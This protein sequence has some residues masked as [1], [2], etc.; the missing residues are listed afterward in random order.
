MGSGMVTT[1]YCIICERRAGAVNYETENKE[2]L[3]KHAKAEHP[4]ERFCLVM[5]SR[6][7]P[8][9]EHEYDYVINARNGMNHKLKHYDGVYAK[10]ECGCKLSVTEDML[11]YFPVEND[12]PRCGACWPEEAD[13]AE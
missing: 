12:G 7:V 4:D 8:E 11:G 1:F 5:G 9:H 3:R 2:Q 6:A 10:A 13:D